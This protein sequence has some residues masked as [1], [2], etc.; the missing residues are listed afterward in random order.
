MYKYHNGYD[1]D[2]YNLI[3]RLIDNIG[4]RYNEKYNIDL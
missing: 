2:K 4:Y 1:D 3:N